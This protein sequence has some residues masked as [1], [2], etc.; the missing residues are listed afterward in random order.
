VV[1]GFKIPQKLLAPLN[2]LKTLHYT[3]GPL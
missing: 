1:Q 3:I 2:T